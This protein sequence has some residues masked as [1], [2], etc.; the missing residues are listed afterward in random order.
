MKKGSHIAHYLNN[1]NVHCLVPA[2][3]EVFQGDLGRYSLDKGSLLHHT[4]P[5]LLKNSPTP[6]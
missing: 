2:P 5:Q 4:D 3:V 6:S 1:F